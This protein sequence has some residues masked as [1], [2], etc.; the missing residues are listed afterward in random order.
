MLENKKDKASFPAQETESRVRGIIKKKMCLA[1]QCRIGRGKWWR[2]QGDWVIS[3]ECVER[4]LI[5]R[6]FGFFLSESCHTI[7]G[8]VPEEKYP[9]TFVVYMWMEAAGGSHARGC[10]SAA[11]SNCLWI[12]CKDW[13]KWSW[14]CFMKSFFERGVLVIVVLC[15]FGAY[16]VSNQCHI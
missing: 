6:L 3:W 5:A 16:N 4:L 13:A 8:E 10:C 15:V 9:P 2:A 14:C 11:Q 12:A 1:W 7:H